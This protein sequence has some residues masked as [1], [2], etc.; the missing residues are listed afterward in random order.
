MV[1]HIE[2][3]DM[4]DLDFIVPFLGEARI[5]QEQAAYN[6]ELMDAE[7][8][9]QLKARLDH[10][11]RQAQELIN[12][13]SSNTASSPTLNEAE[14][15][16][17]ALLQLRAQRVQRVAQVSELGY[18]SQVAR[19]LRLIATR[20]SI[21]DQLRCHRQYVSLYA[22]LEDLWRDPIYDPRLEF[23]KLLGR[24]L[25]KL[26]GV[27]VRTDSAFWGE[28]L[29]RIPAHLPTTY[30]EPA[31]VG[32]INS[33]FHAGD[34]VVQSAAHGFI[35]W[36]RVHQRDLPETLS[37]HLA[38]RVVAEIFELMAEP[39]APLL[40]IPSDGLQRPSRGDAL[41][42]LR[43]QIKSPTRPM[44]KGYSGAG[45]RRPQ[46]REAAEVMLQFERNPNEISRKA[47]EQFRDR[48]VQDAIANNNG[49][50]LGGLLSW[51]G[52]GLLTSVQLANNSSAHVLASELALDCIRW[53]PKHDGGWHLW[54]RS[55]KLQGALWE[56]ELVLWE[57]TRRFPDLPHPFG[58]LAEFLETHGKPTEARAILEECLQSFPR[59]EASY[60]MLA[61]LLARS[62][63]LLDEAVAI[64]DLGL[65]RGAL[66][67]SRKSLVE[68][69]KR[70]KIQYD[71]HGPPRSASLVFQRPTQLSAG[72]PVADLAFL[73]GE[74]IRLDFL[75]THP[76]LQ[77]LPLSR[78]RLKSLAAHSDFPFA[79]F[80]LFRH[81]LAP[82]LSAAKG[83]PGFSSGS[84][85]RVAYASLLHELAEPA[86]I[87][88]SRLYKMTKNEEA[89]WLIRVAQ[90]LLDD[91]LPVDRYID[92]GAWVKGNA[93]AT[94]G[95]S[96]L[97]RRRLRALVDLD[98]T[99]DQVM[100][101]LKEQ[102]KAVTTA[103][104]D[105]VCAAY[106]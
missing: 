4:T 49:E 26:R 32:L 82:N 101:E 42:A 24:S 97:L 10:A 39:A 98:R 103:I 33:A 94:D 16:V 66:R 37:D 105:V 50:L 87:N 40:G 12:A 88:W 93:S 89:S 9:A 92:T 85:M 18:A 2:R 78:Q 80:L 56:A 34:L 46:K 23:Y 86:H 104:V 43:S 61:N 70:L 22:W 52:R 41:L 59:L 73:Y 67:F 48:C 99:E 81:G 64:I 7:S 95:I 15:L 17:D 35:A 45:P 96:E 100:S 54:F 20:G 58:Q 68:A 75:L 72:A 102:Q 19:L 29:W 21:E 1:V 91:Q 77:D 27:S 28:L 63:G 65:K 30:A 106:A 31:V 38:S 8:L 11:A 57:R 79:S 74:C 5:S 44:Q 62:F 60:R 83:T 47:L 55:L 71:Q 53:N 36:A 90:N 6:L 13:G 51:I 25:K 3:D 76:A 69:M 84:T 14:S